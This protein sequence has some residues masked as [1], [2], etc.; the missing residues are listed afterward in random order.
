LDELE[1]SI[2]EKAKEIVEAQNGAS[3][4]SAVEAF[5]EQVEFQVDRTKSYEEQAKDLVGF[6]ATEK[7]IQDEE[8]T[9][10]V[11]DRK[12]AEILNH[13]DAHL[14]KEEAENK[15]AD[16]LLQEANYGVYEGVATY[17]GIKKALPQKMQNILFPILGIVQIIILLLFGIPTSLICIIADEVESVITKLGS[18]AKASRRIVVATIVLGFLWIVYVVVKFFLEK[19]GIIL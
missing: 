19:R 10:G 7:A 11:T 17:A 4:K 14:K 3:Q 1:K 5:K 9:K 8:L 6:K 2:R 15:K 12:K 16:T 18:L 13:A